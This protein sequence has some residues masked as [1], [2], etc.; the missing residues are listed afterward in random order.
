MQE[1]IEKK[2]LESALKYSKRSITISKRE[3]EVVQELIKKMGLVQ[4]GATF[5]AD[6]LMAK[7]NHTNLVDG[8]VSDDGDLLI[9]GVSKLIKA[10]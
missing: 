5:E 10:A 7:L 9:Y 2:D 6:H 1:H 3:I 4:L 8:V